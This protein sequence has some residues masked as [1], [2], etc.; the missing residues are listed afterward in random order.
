MET[1][2]PDLLPENQSALIEALNQNTRNQLET[3]A[4]AKGESVETFLENEIAEDNEDIIE[5]ILHTLPEE[6]VVKK[7]E[8]YRGKDISLAIAARECL[9]LVRK[10]SMMWQYD[11]EEAYYPEILQ[12]I[13]IFEGAKYQ[14]DLFKGKGNAAYVCEVPGVPGV[15]IKF[16]HTPHMQRYSPEREFGILSTVGK[17]AKNFKALNVPHAHA[18]AV[19]MEAHK[20]FFTM[21]TIDG[22]T[23]EQLIELP[24][25]R[26]KF[27]ERANLSEEAII[28]LL[29]DMN[30]IEK[31]KQDLVY[32]HEQG[33]LHGDIHPR[34]IMIDIDGEF[35]LIDFGNAIMV[36][37]L[38]SG[39]TYETVE[40]TKD[41][42]TGAFQNSMTTTGKKL[43]KQLLERGTVA[44]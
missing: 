44:I 27:L 34:N 43:E 38:P 35:H 16:L 15:C 6:L 5:S 36:A 7:L 14:Q 18:V 19:N 31:M 22:V 39:V 12:T 40:N 26:Q 23:L 2:V 24:G 29:G 33:I 41:T 8:S 28:D 20:S 10:R 13:K 25:E 11:G 37:N 9:E 17:I 21:E 4:K 3:F 32:L 1:F 42:D 30:L